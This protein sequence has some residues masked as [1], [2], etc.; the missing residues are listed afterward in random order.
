L[1]RA[2]PADPDVETIPREDFIADYFEYAPGE[3]V[4]FLGPTGSGKTTLASELIHENATRHLP[5][6]ILVIKPKDKTVTDLFL[7][8]KGKYK[9]VMA[10]PPWPWDRD[11]AGFV[12]WPRHT[13]DPDR[14]DPL[15][16]KQMRAGILAGY[17]NKV[18][19]RGTEKKPGTVGNILFCDEVWG[20]VDLGLR[21]ELTTVWTRARA[22][23]CG[24]WAASQRPALIPLAAY[25][26]PEHIFIHYSPDKA[27]RDRYKEIGGVDPDAVA[28]ITERMQWHQFLYINRV[29]RSMYVVDS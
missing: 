29:D 10:W 6:L 19:R 20:L 5:A 17:A 21:R 14:D 8:G 25:S 4:T 2:V 15:L 22:M 12:L 16:R 11:K 23:G 28:V 18:G 7:K 26:E 9:K 13:F 1:A 3:H 27:A 24:L